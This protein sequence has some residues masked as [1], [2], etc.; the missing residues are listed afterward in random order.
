MQYTG[1]PGGAFLGVEW[2]NDAV[3]IVEVVPRHQRVENDL[4]E[5]GAKPIA[6]LSSMAAA[7]E[8]HGRH[9]AVALAARW[10]RP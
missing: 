7:S 2:L 8:E 3:L 5:A 1:G 10:L 4:P 6:G 9:A